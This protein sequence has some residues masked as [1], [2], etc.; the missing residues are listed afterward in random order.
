[1]QDGV[2]PGVEGEVDGLGAAA[3]GQHRAVAIVRLVNQGSQ[4]LEGEGGPVRVAGQSAAARGR[5]LDEVRALLDPLPYG[6]PDS[7][8]AVHLAAHEPQMPAS[9]GQRRAGH[10]RPRALRQSLSQ[11]FLE[12][13]GG[14]VP[15]P[16]VA[17][18]G[19]PGGQRLGD[20]ASRAQQAYVV[21]V[22]AVNFLTSAP[23]ARHIGVG[24]QVEQA[25]QQRRIR[26]LQYLLGYVALL[27]LV[28]IRVQLAPASNP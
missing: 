14:V 5:D 26:E 7:R 23:V 18:G 12:G 1:M 19:H 6:G 27:A 2:H 21:G 11:P 10:Q 20:V 24:V 4:F 8:D 17:E 3:V 22:V 25:G 15:G 9:D 16:A 28:Q 13:K